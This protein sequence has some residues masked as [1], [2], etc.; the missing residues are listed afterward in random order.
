MSVERTDDQEGPASLIVSFV[1]AEGASSGA[2]GQET[3]RSINMKHKQEGEILDELMRICA[4]KQIVATPAEEEQLR[5]LESERISG[6][7]DRVRQTKVLRD[8]RRQQ[9]I[10][11]QAKASMDNQ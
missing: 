2:S 1:Q 6:E 9:Q 10:L 5:E 11:K 4:G 8:R 3:T 7:A